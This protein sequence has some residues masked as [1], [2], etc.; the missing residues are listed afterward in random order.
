[1]KQN[2]MPN[3]VFITLLMGISSAGYSDS[4]SIPALIFGKKELTIKSKAQ[5]EVIKVKVEEGDNIKAGQVIAIID[6]RQQ[7]IERDL[8]SVEYKTAN[9]DFIKT[10][11]LNK[12]VSKD[13]I[14]QK[15]AAY[16]KKKSTYD[17][18]ELDLSNTRI[19]SPIDGVVTKNYFD[20]GE[21]ISV[22]EKA[23]EIVQLQELIVIANVPATEISKL[24]KGK[25][26]ELKVADL[27]EKKFKGTVTFISPVIDSAS[28]TIRIKIAVKNVQKPEDKTYYL[29]PGMLASLNLD[30]ETTK[31]S[32]KELHNNI[33]KGP[34]EKDE[35]Q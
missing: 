3:L 15:E 5:G 23:F 33:S 6:D 29:K 24:S 1:M 35:A 8:A 9:Q 4:K 11:K 13:E 2:K 31:E 28:E 19:V 17:L 12:Y 14:L 26:V 20:E 7:K 10:K 34:T 30:E 21:R 27:K 16:M 32:L 22:G 25:E 18:K